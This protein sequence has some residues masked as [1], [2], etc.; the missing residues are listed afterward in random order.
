MSTLTIQPASKDNLGYEAAPADCYGTRTDLQLMNITS[1]RMR[2]FAE[3]DLSGLPSGV[4]LDSATL[5]LYYYHYNGTDPSGLT[6][7]AYKLTRTDWSES[8]SSWNAYK[9]G[10]NWTAAG[11]DYVTSSPSG[12]SAT[13]PA[14]YGWMNWD[15]LAI[16]QAAVAAGVAAEFL[17]RFGT[18]TGGGSEA[19]FYSKEYTADTTL[20][21][22]LVITYSEASAPTSSDA[23][24][25]AD[26]GALLEKALVLS[27][28]G[29]GVDASALAAVLASGEGGAG[30]DSGGL[31]KAVFG[32]DAGQ[33]LDALKALLGARGSG[34]KLSGRTGRVG[35]PSREV[36]L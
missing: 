9:S 8:Q 17:L 13:I 2:T 15:V 7:W 21:P 5:Y 36:K 24:A 11:G 19:Y 14:S 27:D 35:I 26:A 3:F 29:A 6:V 32:D 18:E 22:K 16:I 34:M 30:A 1:N 23:G 4:V 25:G 33:G 20:R 31:L 12:G 28:T 10:S